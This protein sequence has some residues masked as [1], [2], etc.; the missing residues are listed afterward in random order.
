MDSEK[1]DKLVIMAM[2]YAPKLVMAILILIIGLWVINKLVTILG[3][4]MERGGV[5]RDILPFLQSLAGV[6]F[7]LMLLFSVAEIVGIQTTSF[8]AVLAAAGFAVGMAL[9]GSLGNFA[10]GVMVLIFKPYRVGDVVEIG[11]NMGHVTEIQ[12]FN[13]IMKTFD[14]KTVVIPNGIA[15]GDVI[16]N[17]T[18]IGYIRVDMNIAVPFDVN[19]DETIQIIKNALI[20][21]T[22]VLQDPAPVVGIDE[23]DSHSITMAIWPYCNVDDYWDV[24]FE[25]KKNVLQA[26]GRNDIRVPYSEGVEMGTIGK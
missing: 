19:M 7:K 20:A 23:F 12:I 13:T 11:D 26:L 9:Q 15:I 24:Y 2:E 17:L 14:N 3:S 6:L 25:A 8:V 10:S 1:L 18:T 22:K 5:S 16:T 21:T 4:T